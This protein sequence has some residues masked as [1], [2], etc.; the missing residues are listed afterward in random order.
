MEAGRRDFK[1]LVLVFGPDSERLTLAVEDR[2]HR[3][4]QTFADLDPE[5]QWCPLEGEGSPTIA[6]CQVRDNL[7][8]ENGLA[9]YDFY[10]LVGDLG[11]P[12]AGQARKM[13]QVVHERAEFH[14]AVLLPTTDSDPGAVMDHETLVVH[15]GHHLLEAGFIARFIH[16]FC[17]FE[18][19]PNL[20]SLDFAD[21]RFITGKS[22][23]ALYADYDPVNP[24][25]RFKPETPLQFLLAII[26]VLPGQQDRLVDIISDIAGPLSK[27]SEERFFLVDVGYLDQHVALLLFV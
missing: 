27:V 12:K 9:G 16:D 2:T 23:Q 13:L 10:F 4:L 19:F 26:F 20:V 6:V 8:S 24:V 18:M 22:V 21:Y 14:L 7:L 25:C 15:A 17:A 11:S 1:A 5:K 3:L